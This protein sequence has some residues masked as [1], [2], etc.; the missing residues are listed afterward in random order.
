MALLINSVASIGDSSWEMGDALAFVIMPL[1]KLTL[2][3]GG[4]YSTAI[5]AADF[6]DCSLCALGQYST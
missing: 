1:G 3:P 5:A 4:S 6:S 2:C